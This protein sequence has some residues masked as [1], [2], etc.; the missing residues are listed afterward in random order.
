[1]RQRQTA[2]EQVILLPAVIA[3]L[4]AGLARARYG[5]RHLRAPDLRLLWLVPVAFF[6][7]WLAFYAPGIRT[8]IGDSNLPLALVGSQAL[9]LAFAWLNRSQ[10][11][12]WALGLGLALNLLVIAINGGLMPVSPETVAQ[13]LPT[14][15]GDTWQV[16]TQIGRNVVLNLN[17]TR[18]WWLSD[19][20]LLPAGFPIRKALSIG[21]ILI[22][23]GAFWLL[24]SCG[25]SDTGT[26]EKERS[27]LR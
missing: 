4:L 7:Q 2:A 11:G 18:L 27:S 21:D 8:W 25:G 22:A 12:M 19:W 23:A 14:A 1:V 24:W 15:P 3:G 26:I 5:N 6:I 20:I 16:G 13:L 9:L 17:D 10:Q